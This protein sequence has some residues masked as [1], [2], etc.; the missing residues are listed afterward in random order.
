M[1]ELI[2]GVLDIAYSDANG[3]GQT[4]TGDV[5]QIL[6]DNYGVMQTFFDSRK[7]QIAGFLADGIANALQDLLNGQPTRSSVTYGAEQ[8]IEA[9]FRSFLDS[10]EMQHATI[11]ATGAPL[12]A[13]A[14]KGVNHRRKMP[15]ASKNKARPAFID[16]GL[17]RST[18]R[19]VV[20]L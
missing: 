3:G 18:F 9:E 17:Y 14:A 1:A 16:T 12:S 2:L 10:N 5:A 19:A 4:T 15:Y 8:R 11:A 20:K 13:A 7:E 6:E